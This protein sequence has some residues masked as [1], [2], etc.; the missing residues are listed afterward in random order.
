MWQGCALKYLVA[1]LAVVAALSLRLLLNPF[2][3]LDVPFIT[4]FFAVMVAAW[5]GGLG[6]GV[7]AALFSTIVA[8][9]FFIVPI[10]ASSFTIS[11]ALALSVFVME[12]VGI[13]FLSGRL[14]LARHEAERGKQEIEHILN[15]VSD[16][17]VAV[18]TAWRYTMVNRQAAQ[19]LGRPEADLLGRSLWTVFPEDTGAGLRTE[20]LEAMRSQS[21]RSFESCYA[22]SG[23]WFEHRLYPHAGGLSVF[24][25]DITERKQSEQRLKEWNSELEQR[26][27]ERT[28]TLSAS[29]ARLRALAVQLSLA[30]QRER[31]R[32]ATELHD[33]L[34]QMLALAKIKLAQVRRRVS[35]P[36]AQAHLAQEIEEILAKS[37]NYT[38]TMIAEL[39]PPVLHQLGLVMGIRWLAEQMMRHGLTLTVQV[40]DN[41]PPL[42]EDRLIL[43]FQCVRE[44][45][46]NVVK[47][48]GTE[49][50]SVRLSCDPERNLRIT[51]MDHGKGFDPATLTGS[52]QFGLYSIRERLEAMGGRL[53]L[54]SVLGKGT[55]ATL[56]VPV[57]QLAPDAAEGRLSQHEWAAPASGGVLRVLLVDDHALVRQGLESVLKGYPDLRIVGEA[58]NGQEALEWTRRVHPDVVLMD[59]NMPVMDGVEATRRIKQELP[60]TI[61][62]GLSVNSNALVEKAMKD[63][64]AVAYLTKEMA[65]DKLHALMRGVTRGIPEGAARPP[66]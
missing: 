61:V 37:L 14:H 11:N 50:A 40:E 39:S 18:D 8:D 21:P 32:V 29:Q 53:D 25:S 34:A 66:A 5:Y 4:F 46:L 9:Y 45:L 31:R 30:E 6:P 19:I 51:V 54:L 44:L 49:S 16:A 7:L 22:S 36:A 33:S 41:I 12:A 42:A 20:F 65:V 24:F 57:G 13:S 35:L 56:A 38:R 47:H 48:A 64:G 28:M 3:S 10:G 62:I 15:S 17:F 58:A 52:D 63:A 60:A 27:H 1:I 55:S 23:R 59:V 2:L 26:V 43:S